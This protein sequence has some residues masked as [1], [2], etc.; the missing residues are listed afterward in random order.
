MKKLYTQMLEYRDIL[1]F[2]KILH[3]NP[4]NFSQIMKSRD[5]EAVDVARKRYSRILSQC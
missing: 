3:Q 5:H 1:A 4:V 2:S